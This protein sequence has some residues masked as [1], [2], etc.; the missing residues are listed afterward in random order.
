LKKQEEEI[1]LPIKGKKKHLTRN[2]L[3]DYFGKERCELTNKV[4][5]N[6][7]ESIASSIPE[8]MDMII[9]SFLSDDMKKKYV[10]LLNTRLSILKIS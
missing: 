8:W 7:L 4:V 3:I 2:I 1:A 6:V 5:D 10:D 9:I